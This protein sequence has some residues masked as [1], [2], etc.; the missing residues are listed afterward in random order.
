MRCVR[1]LVRAAS[2][3]HARPSPRSTAHRPRCCAE[4]RLDGPRAPAAMATAK[5][6][7]TVTVTTAT[8]S[9]PQRWGRR[10]A[11]PALTPERNRGRREGLRK[12]L[13]FG[14]GVGGGSGGKKSPAVPAPL[15]CGAIRGLSLWPLASPPPH[16]STLVL[17]ASPPTG[18]GAASPQH[19]QEV[20]PAGSW[21]E[22]APHCS[23]C[24][25]DFER[26]LKVGRLLKRLIHNPVKALH[27]LFCWKFV[28]IYT[29]Y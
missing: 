6:T 21:G 5:A 25:A 9:A 28:Y 7:V 23:F 11:G 26:A 19:T 27:V 15:P 1:L 3:T 4:P 8:A 16:A 12:N 29:L 17:Q 2:D 20:R 22:L 18:Q 24:F 13:P 14:L 10:S